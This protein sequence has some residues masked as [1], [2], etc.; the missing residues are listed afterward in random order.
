M[1][2]RN[3]LIFKYSL[4]FVSFMVILSCNDRSDSKRHSLEATLDIIIYKDEVLQIFYKLKTD[5]AYL[6]SLS[7][8][9]PVTASKDFQKVHFKLPQG[10]K[11]KNI[12]IDFGEKPGLDSFKIRTISFKYK[13]LQLIGDSK[14]YQKWF[15]LNPNISYDTINDMYRLHP[16]H[17]G[18]YDPQINGNEILNKR[19]VKLFPPD[20]NDVF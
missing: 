6:E 10:I 8:K 15:E 19:L 3:N 13:E 14:K 17:N 18:F 5:D 2:S 16:A 20:I 7:V 12:R 11:P 9:Q 4:F 1:L